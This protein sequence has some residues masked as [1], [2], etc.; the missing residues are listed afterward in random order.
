MNL[1][2]ELLLLLIDKPT[3]RT[4][5]RLVK[6]LQKKRL[7][8]RKMLCRI[9]GRRM[10]MKRRHDTSDGFHWEC[11]HKSHRD[12]KCS[13]T[14]RAK[15]LFQNSK[16]SLSSWMTFIYRFSQGLHLR[17]IDMMQDG[18]ARSSR[19]MS[20]MA[21]TLRKV[22]KCAMRRYTRRSGQIIGHPREFAVIDESSF[23]HKRKR[24]GR[25]NLVPIVVKHV[26][27]GTTIISDEWRA[28]RGALAAMGYTHFRVNH[29][30]WFVDPHSGAHTQHLE[31]AWLK[32]KSTIWRLRG[33]RTEKILKQH[34]SVIEWTHWLAVKHSQGPLGRLLKDIRHHYPV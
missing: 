32:Y 4:T 27:P 21:A 15:S 22:C 1:T 5:A 6:W 34:L 24:R 20:K 12:R 17:Q 14:V 13:R 18:I 31:R 7:L 29:R 10:K 33:N 16:R 30:Q 28:Y 3:K 19:T 23:C 9:C 26:R 11:R 8:A 25:Q 2:T